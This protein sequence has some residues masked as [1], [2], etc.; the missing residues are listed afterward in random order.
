MTLRLRPLTEE[1]D[2]VITRISRSGTEEAR[3]VERAR[4][5]AFAHDGLS[6]KEIARRMNMGKDGSRPRKWIRRFNEQGLEGLQDAP[7]SGAPAQ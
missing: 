4:M 7:R 6:A 3:L 5:L 1:E 2:P